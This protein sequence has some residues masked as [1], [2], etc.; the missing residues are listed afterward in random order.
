MKPILLALALFVAL[1]IFAG[2]A[3]DIPQLCYATLEGGQFCTRDNLGKVQVY[4]YNAGWCPPCNSE[5]GELAGEVGEFDGQN[6]IFASLSGEGWQRGS[7]PDA[8]F[9]KSW[10]A[11]HHIPAT[12]VIAGKFRDFGGQF[13]NPGSIPF[14]VIVDQQGNKSQ[15]GFLSVSQIL[16]DVRKL[17]A[18]Y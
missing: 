3:A 15:S 6:V 10:K 14:A 7:K 4:L 9:L 13:G 12:L 18:T 5:M 8:T 16:G 1:P 17:L 2:D 11:K